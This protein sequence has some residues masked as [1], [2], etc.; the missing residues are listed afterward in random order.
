MQTLS[1]PTALGLDITPLDGDL[2]A[3]TDPTGTTALA[4]DP[5]VCFCGCIIP[6]VVTT[7]DE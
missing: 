2:G 7:P 1:A 6:C 3:V 5:A 4:S